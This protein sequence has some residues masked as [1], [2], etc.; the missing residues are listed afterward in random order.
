MYH[1]IKKKNA[2][3]NLNKMDPLLKNGSLNPKN[4]SPNPKK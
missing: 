3:P 4:G 1:L 2:S